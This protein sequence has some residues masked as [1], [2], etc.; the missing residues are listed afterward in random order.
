MGPDEGLNQR[1]I[2]K[3][4]MRDAAAYPR[5]E[6]LLERVAATL[7]PALS[8]SAPDP[9][10]LPKGW[11][12]I[13]LTKRVRDGK[14][15]LNMYQAVKG[16]GADL[17]EAVELLTAAARPILDRWFETDVLKATLATDA[18]IGAFLSISSPGERLRTLA[19]RHG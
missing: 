15:L 10:P 19:S 13:G 12:D 18:I 3:F 1:E 4:S 14:K 9:L 8:Q 17:P 16:L 6:A 7:E 2:G 5:Y 11:R